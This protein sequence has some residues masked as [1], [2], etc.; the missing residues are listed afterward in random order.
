MPGV[1]YL[2]KQVDQA[3]G[4]VFSKLRQGPAHVALAYTG[5][6]F[7]TDTLAL[8]CREAVE[9]VGRKLEAERAVLDAYEDEK[10]E[11]ITYSVLLMLS[12]SSTLDIV[13]MRTT[14]FHSEHAHKITIMQP[15]VV[16]ASFDNEKEAKEHVAQ[17][18]DLLPVTLWIKGVAFSLTH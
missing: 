10:T 15:H 14:L 4:R 9:N 12:P 17:L 6:N 16:A 8:C 7:S 1:Y 13:K 18:K 5:E 2:V 3:K 11:K